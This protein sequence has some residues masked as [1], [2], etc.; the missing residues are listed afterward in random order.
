MNQ[1]HYMASLKTLLDSITDCSALVD[2]EITSVQT[3]SRQL[4]AGSLFVALPGGTHHGLKFISNAVAAG[5]AAVVFDNADREK[6]RSLLAEYRQ[7]IQLI[8]VD[9]V[10]DVAGVIADRFYQHP[11]GQ[12]FLVAVTGTDGKTSVT[13]FMAQAM[14]GVKKTAVIG[15]TGNG[16]W[17]S[18]KAA[19]YTTPDMLTLH[20]TLAEFRDQ[21]AEFVAMEVSSHGIDQKRIAGVDINTAVLTNVSRDHLDYHGT[22]DNYRNIKK[23][24]FK[25]AC[26][27]NIVIN[28]DDAV[29]IELAE[30][31][32]ESKNTWVYGFNKTAIEY[33][34]FIVADQVQIQKHGFVVKLKTSLGDFDVEVSL[35]GKFN[36]LNV[37]SVIAVMM[38]NK[39][40]INEITNAIANL[41][42]AT[43]RMEAFS[44]PGKPTAVVD[45][46]HTPRALEQAL[47]S[48]REHYTGKLWCVFGCGGDR[49]QGKRPLMGAVAEKL[50][51]NVIVTDDNP[52]TENSDAIIAQIMEGVTNRDKV[53]VIS[54]RKKAIEFACTEAE[55]A[56]VVLVAGKGHET[57]Q[58]VGDD[59][60]HFSD[61]DTVRQCLG[62]L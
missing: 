4:E 33:K 50:A 21:G 8:G 34:N 62:C 5:A 38:I 61:R 56:D 44:I 6:F 27:E 55:D 12:M 45:F 36:I 60:L 9:S 54:D 7:K 24:L 39:L 2:V 23:Q 10:K 11:S 17:G 28:I 35:L 29:G 26:V 15:T 48:L 51:D 57:Y 59:R 13:R 53:T 14:S 22:V 3:D 43:G 31:L 16:M 18:I 58:I 37:M 49:D 42:T 40:A 25:L 20:M 32:S 1:V 47:I 19:T 46:A 30:E 41:Q 52:R